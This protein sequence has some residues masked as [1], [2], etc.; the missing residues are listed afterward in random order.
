[1]IFSLY[2]IRVRIEESMPIDFKMK[3]STKTNELL[4]SFSFFFFGSRNYG[5]KNYNC[6]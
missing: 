3:W 2:A 5:N 1:M 6:V 4:K